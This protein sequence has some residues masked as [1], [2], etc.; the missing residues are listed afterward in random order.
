MKMLNK[1]GDIAL[2]LLVFVVL[3]AIGAIIF[4][5]LGFDSNIQ[6]KVEDLRKPIEQIAF[7]QQ[8]V[9]AQAELIG[10]ESIKIG[11]DI[12]QNFIRLAAQKDFGLENFGNFFRK[13]REGDFEFYIK[14]AEQG[15]YYLEI[16][17]I[18][19]VSRVGTNE[20]ERNFDIEI[21]FDKMGNLRKVYK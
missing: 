10:K 16:N 11:G 21:E 19:V 1:K 15:V 7:N 14:D 2:T 17:R 18:F 3:V 12:K 13:I 5:F 9:I 6:K 8:Y 20:V 4:G